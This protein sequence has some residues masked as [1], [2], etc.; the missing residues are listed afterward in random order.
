MFIKEKVL[1]WIDIQDLQT[2]AKVIEKIIQ[3]EKKKPEEKKE[4]ETEEKK[5]DSPVKK[6]QL[7]SKKLNIMKTQATETELLEPNLPQVLL[8]KID[9]DLLL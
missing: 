2:H 9:L 7:P 6:S 3:D 1:N 4:E 8:D 5:E